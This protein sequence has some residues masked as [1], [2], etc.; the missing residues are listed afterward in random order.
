MDWGCRITANDVKDSPEFSPSLK[1]QEHAQLSLMGLLR[2][3]R[4]CGKLGRGH[5]PAVLIPQF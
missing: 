5:V 4:H 1:L 3:P 2:R